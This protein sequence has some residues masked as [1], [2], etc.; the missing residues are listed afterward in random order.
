MR[1]CWASIGNPIRPSRLD[2]SRRS[3]GSSR[4]FGLATAS[5]HGNSRTR[6]S[7]ARTG[8]GLD[9]TDNSRM[10]SQSVKRHEAFPLT[11]R[12]ASLSDLGRDTCRYLATRE[13]GRMSIAEAP[14]STGSSAFVRQSSGLVKTG[15]PFRTAAMVIFNNGLGVFMAFF[16]LTNPGVFPKTNLVLAFIIAGIP[17]DVLQHR[18]RHA[19]GRL[20]SLGRRIP[21]LQPHA[22]PVARLHCGDRQ[23][24]ARDLLHLLCALPGLP[25]G[26]R[27]GAEGLCR[28]NRRGLGID[29]RELDRRAVA[30]LLGHHRV[31]GRASR[32]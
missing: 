5:A 32:C 12:L 26:D 28:A 14:E 1:W 6:C 11:L 17:R 19:R 31:H 29:S 16:Y 25:A 24:L 9:L 4:S 15:T 13:R 20:R 18:L 3:A 7:K 23:L 10:D 8:R 22:E 2:S 21:L 30:L 27:A